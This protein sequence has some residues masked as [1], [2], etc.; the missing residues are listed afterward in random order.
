MIRFSPVRSFDVSVYPILTLERMKEFYRSFEPD[1]LRPSSW[2]G[3][4]ADDYAV[5]ICLASFEQEMR[6]PYEVACAV[7]QAALSGY[8]LPRLQEIIAFDQQYPE[9]QMRSLIVVPNVCTLGLSDEDLLSRDD[10][11]YLK[12]SVG[13]WA[14]RFN[15]GIPEDALFAFVEPSDVALDSEEFHARLSRMRSL[16]RS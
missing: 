1:P 8:R 10:G 6:Y 3:P 15:K 2:F 16:P 9:E 13:S 12:G 11:P 14:D 4:Q 5:R 7:G